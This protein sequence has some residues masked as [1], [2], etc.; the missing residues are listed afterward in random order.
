LPLQNYSVSLQMILKIKLTAD[1]AW[2]I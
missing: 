2:K 1:V